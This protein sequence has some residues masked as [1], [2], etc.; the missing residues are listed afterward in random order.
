MSGSLWRLNSTTPTY[1]YMINYKLTPTSIPKVC[2]LA[3]QSIGIEPAIQFL[4]ARVEGPS[5]TSFH[6]SFAAAD[7]LNAE[8]GYDAAAYQVDRF[9]VLELKMLSK[10]QQQRA[11]K[12]VPTLDQVPAQ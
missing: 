2:G 3:T 6:E 4:G 7:W 1:L 8:G 11:L 12:L 10:Q 5:L 9:T